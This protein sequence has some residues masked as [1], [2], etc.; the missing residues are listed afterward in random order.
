MGS[1]LA[2]GHS[3]GGLY[4]EWRGPL[5]ASHSDGGFTGVGWGR[6]RRCH[7]TYP[8]PPRSTSSPMNSTGLT[9]PDPLL[10]PVAVCARFEGPADD[11]GAVGQRLAESVAPELG[12][13]VANAL[14]AEAEA[15][16]DG[17]TADPALGVPEAALLGCDCECDPALDDALR[18][19][20]F[21][22]NIASN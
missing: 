15:E 14:D 22:G 19:G 10:F 16:P 3:S 9:P 8:P 1:N 5:G 12:S 21:T 13:L 6:S 2:D 17:E 20:W 11:N 18:G 4:P 7:R